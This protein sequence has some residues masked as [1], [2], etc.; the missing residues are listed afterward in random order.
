M[1]QKKNDEF[2]DTVLKNLFIDVEKALK[3]DVEKAIEDD[4]K[5]SL[6]LSLT[7]FSVVFL[8]H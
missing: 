1:E 4:K 6:H 8:Y 7:L 5:K 3:I 2:I